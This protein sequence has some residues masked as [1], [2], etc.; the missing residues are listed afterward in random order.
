MFEFSTRAVFDR[1][2]RSE[3]QVTRNWDGRLSATKFTSDDWR[4]PRLPIAQPWVLGST[5]VS[6]AAVGV[7][8]TAPAPHTRPRRRDQRSPN[9]KTHKSQY[10]SFLSPVRGGIFVEPGANNFPAPSGATSPGITTNRYAPPRRGRFR[11]LPNAPAESGRGR[12][13]AM[14]LRV[15]P[16]AIPKRQLLDGASPLARPIGQGRP[17][18][19][20]PIRR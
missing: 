13:H 15:H 11:T 20:D 5:P 9:P 12:S 18:D 6:G 4:F 16:S 3:P 17:S 7:P 1:S 2:R 14:T 10:L 19:P 8:P